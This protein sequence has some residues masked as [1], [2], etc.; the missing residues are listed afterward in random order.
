[1]GRR[2]PTPDTI[3]PSENRYRFDKLGHALHDLTGQSLVV[4][5]DGQI[6]RRDDPHQLR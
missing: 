6:P 3:H 2:F 4:G 1:M 5:V